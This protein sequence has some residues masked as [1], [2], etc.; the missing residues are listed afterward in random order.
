MRSK[1]IIISFLICPVA[2]FSQS[3]VDSALY[4][5][6][7]SAA[8]AVYHHETYEQASIFK[9]PQYLRYPFP[10]KEGHPYFLSDNPVTGSLTYED[11]VYDSVP[12]LYDEISDQLVTTDFHH[13]NLLQLYKQNVARFN[14]AA[15]E[16]IRLEADSIAGHMVGAGF[17]EVL[18]VGKS[19]VYKKEIKTINKKAEN[20]EGLTRII[21]SE[22]HYYIF[23]KQKYDEVGSLKSL[24][25][26]FSEH[27]KELSRYLG[28]NKRRFRRHK[29]NVIIRAAVFN[30]KLSN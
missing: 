19:A 9:G 20:I 23:R 26:V 17:Y 27:R 30:E 21:E 13:A 5:S 25:A 24:L 22:T 11:I 6:S 29:E 18:F 7:I 1:L 3:A 15:H 12:L 16:F 8:I 28:V 14:I 4:N 10:I 2:I